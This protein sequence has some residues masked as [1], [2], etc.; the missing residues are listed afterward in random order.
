[1]A[2]LRVGLDTDLRGA[3]RMRLNIGLVAWGQG[4]GD[5][6]AAGVARRYPEVSYY[7][8]YRARLSCR[9]CITAGV[10]YGSNLPLSFPAEYV[11]ARV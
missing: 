1:M 6:F 10:N 5:I 4:R 3:L 7:I 11:P 9:C 2:N 8:K